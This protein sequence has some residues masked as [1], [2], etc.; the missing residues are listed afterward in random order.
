ME[1]EVAAESRDAQIVIFH[2]PP[3]PLTSPAWLKSI[4][5][6]PAIRISEPS[7]GEPYPASA[8]GSVQWSPSSE[9]A[10]WNRVAFRPRLFSTRLPFG[11][12]AIAPSPPPAMRLRLGVKVAPP[13]S[14]ISAPAYDPLGPAM[15]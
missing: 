7:A 1:Q 11:A 10:D 12:A 5:S 13:S 3:V 8:R 6:E 15:V 9:L 4:R 2:R 14:L